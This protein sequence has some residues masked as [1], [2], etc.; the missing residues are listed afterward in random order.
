VGVDVDMVVA[1]VSYEPLHQA[2]PHHLSRSWDR[3]VEVAEPQTLLHT[4]YGE[5][6]TLGIRQWEILDM[7]YT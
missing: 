6:W 7:R 3:A 5:H 1:L 2:V 4:V